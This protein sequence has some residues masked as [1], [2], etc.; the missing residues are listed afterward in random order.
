MSGELES[1]KEG[2]VAT[3]EVAKT[4][5]N[6]IDAIREFGGYISKFIS[7]PI[8][9]SCGILEDKLRYI[10]WERQVSLIEKSKELM[11]KKGFAA[12]DV[13]MPIKNA[14]PLFEYATLEED[15]DL[16]ALWANLLVNGTNSSSGVVL[17]R[18]FIEI[19]GQLSH[20]EAKILQA[21]YGLPF[22]RTQH[23]GVLTHSLP[24]RAVIA[25]ENIEEPL[26]E[27]NQHVKIALANL[28]RIGCLKFASSY[29]GGEI[30]SQVNPTFMGKEFVRA[31]SE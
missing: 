20:L 15:D 7:G 30:F 9:Q 23:T 19:L 17:E 4:A 18:S 24:E 3:Q 5:S 8:E 13:Q 14:I 25:E 10:R 1:L 6:A 22:E 2:A 16:Q 31:C 27:P 11:K 26:S 12:P 28:V 29:G 21:I